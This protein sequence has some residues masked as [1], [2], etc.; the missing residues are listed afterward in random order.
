MMG[1][2]ESK[3]LSIVIERQ[4]RETVPDVSVK[5]TILR[6]IEQIEEATSELS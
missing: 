2:N 3:E 1:M 4:C 5:L 6:L